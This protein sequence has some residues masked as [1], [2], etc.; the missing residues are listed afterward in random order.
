MGIL[1]GSRPTPILRQ[2]R[3]DLN[4]LVAGDNTISDLIFRRLPAGYKVVRIRT[5]VRDTGGV[6][7]GGAA[8]ADA[9][10]TL[11]ARF[12]N[13]TTDVAAFAPTALATLKALA[14]D[15]DSVAASNVA[16]AAAGAPLTIAVGGASVARLAGGYLDLEIEL[17]AA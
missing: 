2:A 1:T 15:V 7:S 3:I 11:G 16:I 4:G 5:R 8:I 12:E 9:T 13:G 14:G 17:S 10:T 6:D